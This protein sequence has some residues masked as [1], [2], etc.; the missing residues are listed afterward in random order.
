[1]QKLTVPVVTRPGF[2]T[3]AV[4]VTTVSTTTLL[5]GIIASVVVVGVWAAMRESN[6]KGKA[7][8]KEAF[9]KKEPMG[10]AL[11][12]VPPQTPVV[13][14]RKARGAGTPQLLTTITA[15]NI[16]VQLKERKRVATKV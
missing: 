14:Y 5:E 15:K 16:P 11:L 2:V 7:R 12:V 6:T 1:L 13:S 3:V 8:P 4:R 10:R 9:F